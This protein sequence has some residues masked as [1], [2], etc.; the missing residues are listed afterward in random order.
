MKR[1]VVHR[2]PARSRRASV[3][4]WAYAED[5]FGP[6]FRDGGLS[7]SRTTLRQ[8]KRGNG[9]GTGRTKWHES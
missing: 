5:D 7:R 1:F 2:A 4:P 8:Q 6:H 3:T 9:N